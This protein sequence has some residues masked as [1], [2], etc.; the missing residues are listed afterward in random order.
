M[1]RDDS[2]PKALS[3]CIHSLLVPPGFLVHFKKV[4]SIEPRKKAIKI[5]KKNRASRQKLFKNI[6]F[7]K[8]GKKIYK[9]KINLKINLKIT[10]V[11]C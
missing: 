5:N 1:V 3:Y 8:Y 11:A 9:Y 10:T 7:N 4:F 2:V 6:N